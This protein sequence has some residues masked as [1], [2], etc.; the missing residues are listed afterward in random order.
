GLEVGVEGGLEFARQLEADDLDQDAKHHREPVA[1]LG[2][3]PLQQ[4]FGLLLQ[5][6]PEL[7]GGPLAQHGSLVLAPAEAQRRLVLGPGLVEAPG[8]GLAAGVEEVGAAE[9]AA[10]TAAERVG[11]EQAPEQGHPLR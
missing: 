11:P 7:A 1:A 6:R 10:Q 8:L 5:A 9:L 3:R 4:L 2:G